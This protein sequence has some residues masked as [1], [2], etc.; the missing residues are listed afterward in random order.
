[1]HPILLRFLST[2]KFAA[3]RV[4]GVLK[5]GLAPPPPKNGIA[6]AGPRGVDNSSEPASWRWAQLPPFLAGRA[7]VFTPDTI[8]R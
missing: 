1:M 5:K 8:P 2:E 7:R 3:N 6:M 4:Y